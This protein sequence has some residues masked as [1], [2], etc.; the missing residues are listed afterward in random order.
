[1]PKEVV[2]A[3]QLLSVQPVEAEVP[4]V[5]VAVPPD[6]DAEKPEQQAG[7]DNPP[8]AEEPAVAVPESLASQAAPPE[9]TPL[10]APAVES[11]G[12]QV[13]RFVKNI[14]PGEVIRFLDGTEYKFPAS[15]HVVSDPELAQKILDVA[16]RHGIVL[17]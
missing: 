3:A 11:V 1:M 15:L 9:A 8:P 10:P 7:F 12:A 13:W 16:D 6:P 4:E 14:H 2:S 17:Q 5:P